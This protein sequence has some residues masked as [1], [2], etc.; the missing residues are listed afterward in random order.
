M[1]RVAGL[2]GMPRRLRS[3]ARLLIG[4]LI[5]IAG[6]TDPGFAPFSAP[7]SRSAAARDLALAPLPPERKTAHALARN[8]KR[9]A[10]EA[11]AGAIALAAPGGET[12]ADVGYLAYSVPVAEPA[13]RPVAFAFNGGPGSASTWLQLGALGP[14]R[15]PM[16]SD[17]IAGRTK[18][19]LVENAETWLDFT[20]L[21]FIDPPG[22]G[23]SR[24][25][26]AQDVPSADSRP[27]RTDASG[28]LGP[29][30]QQ[31]TLAPARFR[32]SRNQGGPEWFWSVEGDIETF[33]EFIATWLERN[34]RKGSPI[35]IVGES[36]GGFRAP[37]IADT[38]WQEKKLR[39]A[40]MFLVSPV[41]DF[42]GR[43]GWR[44][45][46]HYVALLPS[47]AATRMERTGT[48][49]SRTLLAD[50]E[51]Y[52][53]GP[54]LSDLMQGPRDTG[55]VQ[56][57]SEAVAGFSGL[58]VPVVQQNAGRITISAFVEA[59]SLLKGQG[60][61][62]YDAGMTG[63]DPV[64]SGRRGGFSDAFTAG[65]DGPLTAAMSTLYG[66]VE[67]RPDRP[68]VMLSS[69]TNRRWRW[70]NAPSAPQ[71]V[72]ALHQL[73]RGDARIRTHVSH[74]FTDLVTPYFASA[75]QLDQMPA[76][77]AQQRIGLEV[78][79]GGHMFYSRDASRARFRLDAERVLG[80]ALGTMAQKDVERRETP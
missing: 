54:Y 72:A 76:H 40:A 7:A 38:L 68:Y 48:V 9:L 4:L 63:L 52:A 78:Y 8:G 51:R 67:W 16:T 25:W 15:V 37:L 19:D 3:I 31:G 21:V 26:P 22:T 36:Y 46:Q 70:P 44:T 42:D 55:A 59:S 14:W 74:G 71:A 43:R 50:V 18:P 49:P 41:I 80:E 1:P 12:L 2:Y 69:V 47:L 45:P 60:V 17:V 64:R 61:S 6:A 28:R 62:I 75:L 58:P 66:R 23:Y 79:A 57:M 56:R 35:V 20:D 29:D 5:A 53:R 11:R 32:P 65:L 30:E 33:V 77:G 34:N 27:A 10:F 24:V 73:H 39:T 13:M